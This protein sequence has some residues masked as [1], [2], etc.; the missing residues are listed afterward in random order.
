MS[1]SW[2]RPFRTRLT[3]EQVKEYEKIIDWVRSL[4]R[5]RRPSLPKI[6]GTIRETIGVSPG[7]TSLRMEI[8]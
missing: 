4:P 5:E 8:G 6:A 1:T 2:N 3:A 7:M